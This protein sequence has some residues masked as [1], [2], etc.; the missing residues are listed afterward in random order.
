V[1]VDFYHVI[2]HHIPEDGGLQIDSHENLES[3]IR[4]CTSEC[5][6]ICPLQDEIK[7]EYTFFTR[8][9]T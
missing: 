8:S 6:K 4:S 7:H 1:L 3:Q 2:Q 5:A 9:K